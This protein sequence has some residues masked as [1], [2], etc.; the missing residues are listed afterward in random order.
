[1]VTNSK[2]RT[3]LTFWL[4]S[5]SINFTVDETSNSTVRSFPGTMDGTDFECKV[6]F[7]MLPIF[8]AWALV[9]SIDCRVGD[10]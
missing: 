3:L 6:A 8:K 4:F 10:V 7:Y 1:M 5:T 9:D 2:K